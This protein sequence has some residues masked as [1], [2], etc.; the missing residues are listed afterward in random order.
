MELKERKGMTIFMMLGFGDRTRFRETTDLFN[1]TF[2]DRNP[3]VKSTAAK[4][5]ET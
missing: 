4:S 5:L 2:S 3:I 1:A